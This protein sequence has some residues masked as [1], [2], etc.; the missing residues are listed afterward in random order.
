ML[1]AASDVRMAGQD[2]AELFDVYKPPASISSFRG[3]PEKAG[4]SKQRKLVH[5]QGDWHRAI[6]LWLY[7]LQGNLIIQQRCPGH[8][9]RSEGKDT[10][11]GKWDVSIAGA[12][13]GREGSK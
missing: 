4:I 7:D 9:V 12:E 5:T 8:V 6:H 11:P 2:L 3:E 13:G 1:D 10:F